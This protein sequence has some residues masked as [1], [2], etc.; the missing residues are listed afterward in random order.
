MW[1]WLIVK[2]IYKQKLTKTI[3]PASS[4]R[5]PVSGSLVT[6]AVKPTPLLPRPVVLIARGAMFSTNRSSWDLPHEGSPTINTL[7]SPRIWV[8]FFKFF[9]LPPICCSSRVFLM[10]SENTM[11]QIRKW[12]LFGLSHAHRM[13]SIVLLL[14]RERERE[15]EL[16]GQNTIDVT[17]GND[18]KLE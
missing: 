18:F 5:S 16:A 9:S 15:R 10:N 14:E 7:I 4:R 1:V 6:A 17:R 11:R 2:V 13:F 12:L 3:A 8:P